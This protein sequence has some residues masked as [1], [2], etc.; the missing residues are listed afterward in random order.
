ML[1]V[2]SK[3]QIALLALNISHLFNDVYAKFVPTIMPLMLR[4]FNLNLAQLGFFS[5]YA[6]LLSFFLQ[7]LFGI[8][9]DKRKGYAQSLNINES[10]KSLSKNFLQSDLFLMSLGTFLN[11]F[12]ISL[13]PFARSLTEMLIFLTFAA[14]GNAAFHPASVA[15]V[16][17]LGE[18]AKHEKTI[19]KFLFYGSFGAGL[20][21]LLVYFLIGKPP[22]KHNLAYAIPLCVIGSLLIIFF[23]RKIET[24]S[25][26]RIP[27]FNMN[28]FKLKLSTLVLLV[29]FTLSRS[30]IVVTF[31]TFLPELFFDDVNKSIERGAYAS[32]IFFISV[33][34]G[35]FAGPYLIKSLGNFRL[36]LFSLLFSA[37]LFF[38]FFKTNS[39]FA[40]FIGGFILNLTQALVISIA[41]KLV[42]E[43]ASLASSLVMGVPWG[44]AVMMMPLIGFVADH[45]GLFATMQYGVIIF[46]VGSLMLTMLLKRNKILT[47]LGLISLF[48][49]SFLG[50]SFHPLSAEDKIISI[51]PVT[52]KNGILKVPH[53]SFATIKFAKKLYASPDRLVFDIYSAR[54]KGPKQ[55]F[56]LDSSAINK[57]TVAQFEN[58]VVRIVIQSTDK[59]LLD[60]VKIDNIGQVIY[61]NLDVELSKIS[62]IKLKAGSLYVTADKPLNVRSFVLE[63]PAR[64]VLDII[65]SVITNPA[66]KLDTMNGSESIKVSQFNN[67]TTRIV[68][69]GGKEYEQ[70]E[71]KISADEKQLYVTA[72][73]AEKAEA[74]SLVKGGRLL[75]MSLLDKADKGTVFIVESSKEIDYKLLYL[76]KPER[77]VLDLVGVA[78][79]EN[80]RTSQFK[81]TLYVSGMRYG[82]ATLGAPVTRVVFDLKNENLYADVSTSIDKKTLTLTIIPTNKKDSIPKP[83]HTEPVKP[84]AEAPLST[85]DTIIKEGLPSELPV[86]EKLEKKVVLDAGHGGYDPGALYDGHAEKDITL[87]ITKKVKVLLDSAGVKTYM[88]RSEDRFLSLAERVE[89]SKSISPNMFVSVHVNALA[90]NSAMDGL[91]T[92]YYSDSGYDLA[93]VMHR[94]ILEVGM[95]DRNIRKAGFW[96]CKHN[97]APSVLLELG[98]M[99]NREERKKLVSD[100]YQDQLAKHIAAGIIKY[101]NK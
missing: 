7:P 2:P 15:F 92:Y 60:K 47:K 79:D 80:L 27:R 97:K 89:I 65:A 75:N 42:P 57:V 20:S 85:G 68:F 4:N 99:T 59:T 23:L 74:V 24:S 40:L 8:L 14:I 96:V 101:L 39:L 35:S 77:Y 93:K 53:N 94:E 82:L 61:F 6:A 33:A 51:Q 45:Y 69:S 32:T 22:E 3:N 70:R 21:P 88:T 29:A 18:K 28:L 98:F 30:L 71:I 76:K 9:A 81:P 38:I 91:Q 26:S 36:I 34:L 62:D 48:F 54:L 37:P 90:T 5:T 64:L 58:D 56:D 83:I 73:S 25:E 13:V 10:E 86:H 44:L 63:N 49:V 100:K 52:L 78:F 41:Q 67:S 11:G 87:S 50:L 43:K 16:G 84:P 95:P 12:F 66:L 55:I 17:S 19:A 1:L 46:I 72:P 31:D